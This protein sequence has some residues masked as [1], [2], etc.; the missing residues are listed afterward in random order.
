MAIGS[1]RTPRTQLVQDPTR[2]QQQVT[3]PQN[4]A[5]L[6]VPAITD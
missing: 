6:K 4:F 5:P 1:P 2:A 3:R